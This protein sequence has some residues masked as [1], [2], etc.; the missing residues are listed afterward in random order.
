[1]RSIVVAI[2][3]ALLLTAST[4]SSQNKR[5]RPERV[6]VTNFPGVQAVEVVNPPAV[7]AVE[8]TNQ[9]DVQAVEIVNPVAPTPAPP[10]RFQLVGFTAATYNGDLGG[11]FGAAKTC[12]LEFEGSRMCS[13]LEVLDTV[14]IPAAL[15]GE[16]W[17]MPDTI[18]ARTGGL[19]CQFWTGFNGTGTYVTSQG[20]IT[21][22]KCEPVRAIACCALVP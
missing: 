13:T 11:T 1:M 5:N 7:Q 12:Q 9:P 4:A 22:S 6:K 3:V 17:V 18:D 2:V 16:A 21:S 15:V 20:I 19:T 8:V 14:D 10:M